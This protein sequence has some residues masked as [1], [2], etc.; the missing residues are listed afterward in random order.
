M[1]MISCERL[2]NIEISSENILI[3]DQILK[4]Q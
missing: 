1:V 2:K 3:Q 4:Q